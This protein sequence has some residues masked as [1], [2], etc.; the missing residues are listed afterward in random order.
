MAIEIDEDNLKRGLLGLVIT[1]VEII[2]EALERQVMR[3][4]ESGRLT[5]EEVERLGNAL[6]E[7]D[8]ALRHIK[9]EN[10]IEE[11][12]RDV[13]DELDRITDDVVDEMVNPERWAER[14]EEEVE[15]NG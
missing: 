3:R 10:G 2:K 1:L 4:M 8:E 11:T 9:R 5:D 14:L 15:K 12:V 7:L 13:R 6:I